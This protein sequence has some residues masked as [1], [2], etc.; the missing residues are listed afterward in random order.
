MPPVLTILASLHYGRQ[1]KAGIAHQLLVL[2]SPYT[3]PD[4]NRTESAAWQAVAVTPQHGHFLPTSDGEFPAC[5]I[6][7]LAGAVHA[8]KERRYFR[9]SCRDK[10]AQVSPFCHVLAELSARHW[11]S[12]CCRAARFPLDIVGFAAG[13]A[14]ALPPLLASFLSVHSRYARRFLCFALR[15][16]PRSSIRRADQIWAAGFRAQT[17]PARDG[18]IHMLCNGVNLRLRRSRF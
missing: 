6:D 3:G 7:R 13:S 10:V 4:E 17:V 9:G 15:S 8:I 5:R 14:H 16:D 12:L 18:Y 1:H 11:E 2:S